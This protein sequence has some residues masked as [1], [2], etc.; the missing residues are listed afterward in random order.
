[1][2]N[3]TKGTITSGITLVSIAASKIAVAYI[4]E[5]S[6]KVIP[7]LH[8]LCPN[9]GLNSWSSLTFALSFST[10]TFISFDNAT[11]SSSFYGKNSWSGG[12]KSLIVT[13]LPL[14][15]LNNPVKS[16]F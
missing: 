4:S 6:G 5:I 1:M 16:S 13:G 11:I 2:W 9:I 3:P 15:V 10:E 14:I 12:S 7:N 8:P